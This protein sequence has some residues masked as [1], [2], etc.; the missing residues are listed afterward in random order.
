MYSCVM[1][2]PPC[3]SNTLIRGLLPN[4]FVHTLKVPTGVLMGIMRMPAVR[5]AESPYSKYSFTVTSVA[6][7]FLSDAQETKKSRKGSKQKRYIYKIVAKKIR[8]IH[9]LKSEDLRYWH[10]EG[11]GAMFTE[12]LPPSTV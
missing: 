6:P 4:L 7:S 10:E 9:Y 2:G 1:A 3:S 12:L 8:R 5:T 11:I